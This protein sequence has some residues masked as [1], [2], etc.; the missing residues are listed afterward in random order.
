[1]I[2]NRTTSP[3]WP[4]IPQV[5]LRALLTRFA[6]FGFGANAH[7]GLALCDVINW[8]QRQFHNQT[9]LHIVTK[10]NNNTT[11]LT[12]ICKT[13]CS[14]L[15]ISVKTLKTEWDLVTCNVTIDTL[16]K[17]NAYLDWVAPYMFPLEYLENFKP[18]WDEAPILWELLCLML[19]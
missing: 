14:F 8:T 16:L 13:I 2:N 5:H 15:N 10:F 6:H 17:Y 1:M 12:V 3:R 7:V 4:L 18:Y 9:R 11:C 19:R